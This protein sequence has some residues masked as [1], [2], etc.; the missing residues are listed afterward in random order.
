MKFSCNKRVTYSNN[1]KQTE[2]VNSYAQRHYEDILREKSI[3]H[4]K[5]SWYSRYDNVQILEF[6]PFEFVKN[7][8]V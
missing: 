5:E 8:G 6:E 3:N 7:D 4:Y 2:A 1:R